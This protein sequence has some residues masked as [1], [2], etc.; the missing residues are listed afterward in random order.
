MNKFSRLS[1]FALVMVLIVMQTGA[2]GAIPGDIEIVSVSSGGMQGNTLSNNASVSADGRYVAF[3]SGPG[4]SNL[5]TPNTNGF[6]HIFVR[7]RQLGTTVLVSKNSGGTAGTETSSRPFISASGRYIAFESKANDLV[8]DDTN[9]AIDIFVHD[10]QGST[11]IRVSSNDWEGNSFTPVISANER[12]V[13]FVSEANNPDVEGETFKRA[14]IFL[15]DLETSQTINISVAPGGGD[16]NNASANPSI[17]A[18]GRFIAFRSGASNLT[19]NDND[20]LVDIFVR[21]MQT[22]TTTLV[23]VNSNGVK[24]NS[25]SFNPVIS[26]DGRFVAFRSNA[27]NLVTGDTNNFSDI[28]VHDRQTGKTTRVSVS[29]N[30]AQANGESFSPSISGNGRFIAF[31]TF[32]NNLISGDTNLTDVYMHDRLTGI[33]RRTSVRSDGTESNGSSQTPAISADGRFIA[34]HS[35]ATNLILAGTSITQIY[36]QENPIPAVFTSNAKQDGWILEADEFSNTGGTLNNGASTLNVGDDAA[37][38]QYRTVLSFNTAALTANAEITK[39]TLKVRRQGVTGGGNPITIFG[40]FMVD[41]KKGNFGK[42]TLQLTDFQ[43]KGNKTLSGLKPK[44]VNGWYSMNLTPAIPQINKTGMTQIRLRFKLDDNNNFTPN[45][46]SLY[47]GNAGAA[48]RPQL[49]VEYYVP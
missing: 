38:R 21:D 24:G 34:F 39:A 45:F 33:T 22:G 19:A 32:S 13:A 23:S 9:N 5:V 12:Y 25:N 37:N 47:S 27:T 46:L 3:E 15:H 11:T 35:S 43:T 29:S 10:L 18:D 48:N 14:D 8:G 4:V 36:V 2:A 7:D 41:V 6:K 28:F 44:L 40:G 16:A 31:E 1:F 17:S 49:I 20:T 26:A 42:A 30:G